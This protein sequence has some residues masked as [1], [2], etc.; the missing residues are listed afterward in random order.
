MRM[1]V[2]RW[3]RR[4]PSQREELALY[5][6][7]TIFLENFSFSIVVSILVK[8]SVPALYQLQWLLAPGVVQLVSLL[9]T[10]ILF[11]VD[12]EHSNSS[13]EDENNASRLV[14]LQDIWI[15]SFL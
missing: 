4:V 15:S 7:K 13:A 5:K 1:R 11:H 9:S 3:N 2:L 12:L 10:W 8:I 14:S 6:P